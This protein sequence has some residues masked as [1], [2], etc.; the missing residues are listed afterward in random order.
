[1]RELFRLV[2]RLR[3]STTD[4]CLALRHR[5]RVGLVVAALIL[6]ISILR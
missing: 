6:L 2:A 1:M 5:L 3:C 4:P